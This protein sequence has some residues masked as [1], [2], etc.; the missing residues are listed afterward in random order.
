MLGRERDELVCDELRADELVWDALPGEPDRSV[1][2]VLAISTDAPD[3]V[4]SSMI[5]PYGS[6]RLYM[7]GCI[8][9]VFRNVGGPWRVLL[10]LLTAMR[11]DAHPL[12]PSCPSGGGEDEEREDGED[13]ECV[14][15]CGSS[16]M[17]HSSFGFTG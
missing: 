11:F 8:S 13:G 1:Y 14:E 4:Q 17:F 7:A 12:A 5:D 10:L 3:E 9:N 2:V 16:A 15:P 6:K